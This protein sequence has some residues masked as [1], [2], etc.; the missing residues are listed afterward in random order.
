MAGLEL[1]QRKLNTS[2]VTTLS[3]WPIHHSPR[4]KLTKQLTEWPVLVLVSWNQSNNTGYSIPD[5]KLALG[6]VKDVILTR[7]GSNCAFRASCTVHSDPDAV[8]RSM[9]SSVFAT[10]WSSSF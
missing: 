10:C 7:S 3:D 6:S 2:I 4:S 5:L 1:E 9:G 8:A